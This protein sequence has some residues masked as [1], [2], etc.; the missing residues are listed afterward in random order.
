MGSSSSSCLFVVSS[1]E[2]LLCILSVA[3]KNFFVQFKLKLCVSYLMVPFLI[4]LS[5]LLI[6]TT[7][8]Q[9]VMLRFTFLFLSFICAWN[10]E[11]CI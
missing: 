1:N 7:Q 3:I 6:Y 5:D 10:D 9:F 4:T 2:V 8:S 11:W